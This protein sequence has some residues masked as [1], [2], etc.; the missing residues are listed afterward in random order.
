MIISEIPLTP[1]SQIVRIT[2]GGIKYNLTIIW[3][4]TGYALD[5]ADNLGNAIATGLSLVTGA[6]L[7]AQL[8]HLGIAGA[9][10]IISDGD[11][12][13][14]P[15]YEALGISSHLCTVI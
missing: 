12:S 5:I 1:E 13:L 6:D 3:R 7:L 8:K 14:N 15:A 9:L 10:V 11:A 4:G 2:I